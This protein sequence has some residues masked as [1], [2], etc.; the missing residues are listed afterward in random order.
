VQAPASIVY[1]LQ[2]SAE[3]FGERCAIQQGTD[4]V[5]YAQLWQQA[6]SFAGYLQSQGLNPG[7]RVALLSENS[8]LAVSALYGTLL[9]G[10]IAVTLNAAARARDFAA[11]LK[12][13]EARWLVVDS[14]NAD[15]AAALAELPARPEVICSSQRE[16]EPFTPV[17]ARLM[18]ICAAG[19][20]FSPRAHEAADPACI[21]YT[22][23]TTGSPKGVVLTHGNLASNNAAIVEYLGLTCDDSV[24]S[25]LPF[26]YSYGSSVLHTHIQVGGRL[27]LE[28]NFVY[29]HLVVAA[30]AK[31]RVTGFSGV[32][33]TYALLLNR[34]DLSQYD[35]SSLRYLTQAGGAMSPAL[36]QRLR[37]KVPHAKLFVMYGQTEATAR[38]TYLPPD[39]LDR[40]LGSVGIAVP[41][42]EIQVRREDGTAAAP[43]ETGEVW[44][45]GP[46]VM[47]GYWRNPEATALVLQDGWLKTGDMGHLDTDGYLHLSGRRSD[48]IKTG[49]H[50]VH[51]KD[52]EEVIHEIEGVAEVAV[53]GIE[54]EI[55]GQAIAAFIVPAPGIELDP[56]KVKT[57]CR[58]RLASYKIPKTIEFVATLPKTASGKVRRHELVQRKQT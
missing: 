26:Y 21:L 10:G 56:L 48:M 14:A 8:A 45:R 44:A 12:H 30:M 43:M 13:C 22:S 32:P 28:S 53:A 27:V 54:D 6:V 11:W 24:L 29:P 1:N 50:R 38:L 37:E 57:H 9:A 33:S 7:D 34:V 52:V 49:A 15:A 46:N 42:V 39:A 55:L 2:R 35:L 31:E 19:L 3:R 58:A 36:T 17:S 20:A 4:A 23:G 5:T 25:I 16:A 47:Q 18:E 51:P 41:G 40:K